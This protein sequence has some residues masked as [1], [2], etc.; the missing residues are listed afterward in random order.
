MDR[1]EFLKSAG[2]LAVGAAIPFAAS[3]LTLA[4]LR[5]VTVVLENSRIDNFWVVVHP[6]VEA[7]FRRIDA[8]GRWKDAY[9]DWRKWGKPGSDHP[10]SIMER[11]G[12]DPPPLTGEFGSYED[13]RFIVSDSVT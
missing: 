13:V 5:R 6:S 9:R 7:D 10:G 4:D 12:Y 3:G 2:A 1:R 8:E 11:Y